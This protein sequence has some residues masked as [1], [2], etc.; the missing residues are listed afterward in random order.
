MKKIYISLFLILAAALFLGGNTALAREEAPSPS[1]SLGPFEGSPAAKIFPFEFLVTPGK[2]SQAKRGE[3]F[4]T[5][6]SA[7]DF[8]LPSLREEPSPILYPQGAVREG[9]EGNFV[10]AIEVLKTGEVGRWK[11][12]HSTG[13]N[14]LDEVATEA[15]Q[16]WKFYPATEKGQPIVSCIEIPIH[17]ELKG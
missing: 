8:V 4:T 2:W 10:I 5:G 3:I 1:L 6:I 14:L 17:F 16:H 12:M 13:Y 7:P 11:I 9:R 15:I